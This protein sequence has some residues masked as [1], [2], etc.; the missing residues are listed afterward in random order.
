M[1]LMSRLKATP[2]PRRLPYFQGPLPGEALVSLG[3]YRE[4]LPP[5][6]AS[7]TCTPASAWGVGLQRPGCGAWLNSLSILQPELPTK[8]RYINHLPQVGDQ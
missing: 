4:R 7:Y 3:A 5:A 6:R 2:L 1:A 8:A